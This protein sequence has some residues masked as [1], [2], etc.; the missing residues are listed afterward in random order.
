MKFH[1]ILREGGYESQQKFHDILHDSLN[2]G[3]EIKF[4]LID[5][6]NRLILILIADFKEKKK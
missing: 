3:Y 1:K 2:D 6:D 5:R 4:A